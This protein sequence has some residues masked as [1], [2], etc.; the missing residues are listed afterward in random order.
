MTG[1]I[2]VQAVLSVVVLLVG[3]GTTETWELLSDSS[4][5]CTPT[6]LALVAWSGIMVNMLV[7]FLQ[8]GGQ[9][10]IG[11]T[12]SQTI[13]ASQP[14]WAAITAYV[15]SGETDGIAGLVGG[16][17]FLSALFLAATAQPPTDDT[18]NAAI[19]SESERSKQ[20]L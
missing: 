7:P 6:I 11:P 15:W 12:R 9:Q 5:W 18:H 20:Q 1:K 13:Y 14:L 3:L 8:V 19:A 2:L 4:T 17:A 16:G 10:A